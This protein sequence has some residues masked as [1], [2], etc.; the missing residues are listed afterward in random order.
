MA[1]GTVAKYGIRVT[2]LPLCQTN[3]RLSGFHWAK[4]WYPRDLFCPVARSF[5]V[6][7]QHALEKRASVCESQT[8]GNG[9]AV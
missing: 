2:S 4:V 7:P 9:L 3:V 8:E 1:D 5:V 6:L